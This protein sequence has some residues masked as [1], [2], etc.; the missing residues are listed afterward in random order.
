MVTRLCT[1]STVERRDHT[2][3]VMLATALHR[4]WTSHSIRAM[5]S[6]WLKLK[7]TPHTLQGAYQIHLVQLE[8]HAAEDER[9][10]WTQHEHADSVT[11]Q[12]ESCYLIFA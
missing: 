12:N 8:L 1:N 3:A 5:V 4:H 6:K 9:Q 2:L 11:Q 10:S 7:V